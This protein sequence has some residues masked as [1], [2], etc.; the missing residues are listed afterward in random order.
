MQPIAD[1]LRDA[2]AQAGVSERELWI[3]YYSLGGMADPQTLNA[4]LDGTLIPS[5]PEYDTIA[6]TLNDVF[7]GRGENHPVPYAEDLAD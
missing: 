4:Y 1:I 7:I 5:R 3:G 6:Q 2:R